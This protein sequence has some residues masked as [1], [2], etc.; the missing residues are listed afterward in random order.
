[1]KEDKILLA[2]LLVANFAGI[3]IASI[4]LT[5]HTYITYSDTEKVYHKEFSAEEQIFKLSRLHGVDPVAALRIAKCESQYGKY[6]VNFQ[7]SSAKGIYQFMP[8]TWKNYCNG[9]MNNQLDQ[10]RCFMKLYPDYP[11]WWSCK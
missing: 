9:D 10:I 3:I 7:G 11:S 4:Y 8:S 6:P 1:M 2:C 5:P